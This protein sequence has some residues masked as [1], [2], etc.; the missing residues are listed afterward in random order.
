MELYFRASQLHALCYNSAMIVFLS[1]FEIIQWIHG[2]SLLGLKEEF[3]S[4]QGCE[5]LEFYIHYIHK[6]SHGTVEAGK[7]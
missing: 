5:S 4:L 2:N 6:T 3:K 1:Y 7:K